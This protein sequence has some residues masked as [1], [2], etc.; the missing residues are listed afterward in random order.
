MNMKKLTTFLLTAT[1]G[2]ASGA[3]HGGRHRRQ[4][5]NG[6]ASSL[7]MPVGWRRMPVKNVAPNNVDNSRINSG[8]GA[9]RAR[10]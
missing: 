2:L 8:S 1:L 6:Q 10:R 7:R 4:S 9:A 3:T 5:N